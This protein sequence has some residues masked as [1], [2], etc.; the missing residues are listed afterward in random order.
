M[1]LMASDTWSNIQ[2]TFREHAAPSRWLSWPP[3]PGGNI[4]GTFREHAKNI[5]GLPDGAHGLRYLKGPHKEHS[6]N[7]Q[8]PIPGTFREY[9]ETNRGPFMN[10]S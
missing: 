7:I 10:H 9:S 5:Q 3:T 1:A 4:Q 2:G 6:G 8:G